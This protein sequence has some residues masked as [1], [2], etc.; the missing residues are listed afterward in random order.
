MI[1]FI[2]LLPIPVLVKKLSTY[3][4]FLGIVLRFNQEAKP[5]FVLTKSKGS[6][7][8]FFYH[9]QNFL[10]GILDYQNIY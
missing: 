1:P 10:H 9:I 5:S 7:C 6:K 3:S 2:L 4:L 8:S